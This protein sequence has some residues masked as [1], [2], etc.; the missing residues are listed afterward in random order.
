MYVIVHTMRQPVLSYTQDEGNRVTQDGRVF[1]CAHNFSSSEICGRRYL[2]SVYF[3]VPSTL[4]VRIAQML[5]AFCSVVD[6]TG[7]MRG[8]SLLH[9][10][11][12]FFIFPR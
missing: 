4:S 10:H 12:P 8:Q 2:T 1:I 5:Y 9:G 7:K 11:I 6:R 3:R